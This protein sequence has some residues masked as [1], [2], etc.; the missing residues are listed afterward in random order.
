MRG[1]AQELKGIFGKRV[2]KLPLDGGFTCPNRER[3]S[4]CLFCSEKGSG[5][6]TLQG[7]ITEQLTLQ[8][9]RLAHK[10]PGSLYLAYFQNFSGTYGPIE[11]L[12]SVYEEAISDDEVVGLAIATRVDCLGRDVLDLLEDIKN[13]TFLWLELGLQSVNP[14][15]M[16]KMNLGYTVEDYKHAMRNLRERDIPVVSHMILGLPGSSFQDEIETAEMILSEGSWGVKIHCLYVQEGTPLA[17]VYRRGEYIPLERDDYVDRVARLL[18]LFGEDV[19]IHRLT[20]DPP[21]EQLL[22]PL[23]IKDKRKVLG[24]IQKE[25]AKRKRTFK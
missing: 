15:V 5:D 25:V 10:W 23:W 7:Q 12:R 19:V 11:K 4:G 20:G 14:S 16:K 21:H 3:G 1:L 17:E 9:E 22:A 2:Q 18:E 13:K 6:F 8:K 24:S